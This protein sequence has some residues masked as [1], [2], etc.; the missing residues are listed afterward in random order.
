MNFHKMSSPEAFYQPL[1]SERKEIRLLTLLPG[2]ETDPIIGELMVIRLGDNTTPYAALSYEWRG[3]ASE[4]HQ[5]QLQGSSFSIRHNLWS[6]LSHL[7]S[8]SESLV[9]WVDAICINQEDLSE[10]SQQ[11]RIM[12]ELY[13][14][15]NMVHAWL[16]TE[17]FKSAFALIRF[18]WN[19]GVK[20]GHFGKSNTEQEQDEP[21]E[22][23][24]TGMEKLEQ[25]AILDPSVFQNINSK[26][27]KESNS[28]KDQLRGINLV[29]AWGDLK[30]L[31]AKMSQES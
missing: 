30:K 7:R 28:T 15:A 5:M 18:I 21:R 25:S 6:A 29:I 26:S 4:I 17:T 20:N 2:S 23:Y 11:V 22:I 9:L 14:S 24:N 12:G 13:S 27:P 31:S 16:G 19:H 3:P 10:R 8:T 1:D